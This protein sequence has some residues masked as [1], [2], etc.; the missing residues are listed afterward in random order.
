MVHGASAHNNRK[1]LQRRIGEQKTGTYITHITQHTRSDANSLFLIIAH[2]PITGSSSWS[3]VMVYAIIPAVVTV[4]L[5]LSLRPSVLMSTGSS[6]ARLAKDGGGRLRSPR[7]CCPFSA[8]KGTSCSSGPPGSVPASALGGLSRTSNQP[9][10]T[11]I[12]FMIPSV[13]A[14]CPDVR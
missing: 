7:G 8:A 3:S 5:C 6:A 2:T 9:V 11:E 14:R 12:P 1:Q 4:L 10:Q 13:A